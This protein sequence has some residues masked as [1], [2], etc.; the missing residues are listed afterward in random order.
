MRARELSQ[1]VPRTL[2][3]P[4]LEM[5]VRTKQC[6]LP[7]AMRECGS[8][9]E[10]CSRQE[11]ENESRYKE[12]FQKTPL[13]ARERG[14]TPWEAESR[15]ELWTRLGQS[16][17]V[18]HRERSRQ[19]AGSVRREGGRDCPALITYQSVQQRNWA[20]VAS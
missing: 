6:P 18:T 1:G 5:R 14:Q 15:K 9:G 19:G 3:G 17:R 2:R 20:A 4:S 10:S 11:V 13:E 16:S 7:L 8:M 12:A